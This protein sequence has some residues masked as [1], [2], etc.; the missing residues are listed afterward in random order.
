[1]TPQPGIL[2]PLST[3]AR[4]LTFKLAPKGDPRAALGRLARS[5]S[6]EQGV[7]GIGAPLASAL[8]VEIPGLRA[9]PALPMAV[10]SQQALWV[11]LQGTEPSALFDANYDLAALIGDDLVL[12]DAIDLFTYKGGRD[13]TGFEDGTE[14]PKDEKAAAAAL[15]P[16]G[17]SFVA[18][19]RWTH[20]LRLFRGFSLETQDQTFG[21]RRETNEEFE[22]AATTAHVKRT[23]QESFDPPA[24]IVRRSMPWMSARE[25]GL[26]FIAYGESLDRYER[27]MRRMIGLEDGSVDALF[28]F[29]KPVTG[30]YF[31]C[32]PATGARLDLRRFGV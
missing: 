4:S 13:L 1:M 20:D 22:E 32:P 15:C 19:Q 29:S 2:R 16:D 23:A 8:R 31:W 25:Q 26:E 21:R 5:F 7:V 30:S 18:V 24:F 11:M 6:L 9:F 10:S 27:V 3:L 12:D 14:N 17:S 28:T